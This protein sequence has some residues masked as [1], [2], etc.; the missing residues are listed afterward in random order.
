MIPYTGGPSLYRSIHDAR[1]YKKPRAS[2][3]RSH[4]VT[5]T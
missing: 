3:L 4:L 1:L 5:S 2:A